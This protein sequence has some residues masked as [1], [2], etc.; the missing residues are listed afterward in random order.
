MTLPY[1]SWPM[2][3]E[4][5]T[6]RSQKATA[7]APRREQ[8]GKVELSEAANK[9]AASESGT[10]ENASDGSGLRLSETCQKSGEVCK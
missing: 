10:C 6:S 3:G 1:I 2:P 7:A 9:P 5:T 4:P 8:F